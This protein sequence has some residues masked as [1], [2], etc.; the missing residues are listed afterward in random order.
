M[1]RR[2]VVDKRCSRLVSARRPAR[3]R[4]D[5]LRPSRSQ[6]SRAADLSVRSLPPASTGLRIG[7]HHRHPSQCARCRAEDDARR[8]VALMID[9]SRPRSSSAATTS[10][11]RSR[12]RRLPSPKR[13]RRSSAAARCRLA[14]SATTMTT[15]TCRRALVPQRVQRAPR[16]PHLFDDL[17]AKPSIS[18]ASVSGRSA[19]WTLR[20]DR[21]RRRRITTLLAH[22]P[23]RLAEAAALNIP[24]VLSGHYPRR[25]GRATR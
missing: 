2:T 1:T 9:S 17:A 15:T 22:D 7:L 24:L 16:R 8:A 19:R 3:P 18:P 20:A 13:W 5:F 10:P 6:V 21:S 23:R 25:P 12:V 4:M 11:G 14:S